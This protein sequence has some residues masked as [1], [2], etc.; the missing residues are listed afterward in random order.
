MG[1]CRLQFTGSGREYFRIWAANVLRTLLTLGFQAPAARKRSA[2]WFRAHTLVAGQ[3]L[4]YVPAPARSVPVLLLLALL[5]VGFRTASQTQ[6]TV[7]AASLALAGALLV[8]YAWARAMRMRLD[9]TRWRGERL[10]FMAGWGE[11]Y[12]A[13][14][15]VF[16]LAAIWVTA[17]L[18]AAAVMPPEV[19]ARQA[20]ALDAHAIGLVAAIASASGLATLLC[21]SRLEFDYDRLLVRRACCG[22][23]PGRFSAA[24]REYLRV[25]A[26]AALL[27]LPCAALAGGALVLLVQGWMAALATG[28]RGFAGTVM[29]IALALASLLVL[30]LA[31][32]PARAYRE[33][34][35]FRLAWNHIGVGDAMRFACDLPVR[36]YVLLRVRNQCLTLLT[37][38]LF[39][40]FARVS[41][42]RMKTQSLTL[43]VLE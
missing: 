40:P 15:P 29:I 37:L 24:W 21:A 1:A 3:P 7:I 23:Q 38:G 4:E 5:Y 36:R 18:A 19:A 2:R 6:H 28:H 13:S 16:L 39:R 14:G 43:R 30:L 27:F 9:A 10:Q 8:P 17:S 11:V 41:E 35:V 22:G 32:G 31:A 20:A 42:Y 25:W 12:R 33:A 34:G 26:I